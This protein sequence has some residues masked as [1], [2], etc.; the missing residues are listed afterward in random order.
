VN[1]T[2]VI[3]GEDDGAGN[4][5]FIPKYLYIHPQSIMIP[6]GQKGYV[7]IVLR[8]EYKLRYNGIFDVNSIQAME[9]ATVTTAY[10]YNPLKYTFFNGEK[11]GMFLLEITGTQAFNGTDKKNF[12]LIVN[13]TTVFNP[14]VEVIIVPD[15]P[16]TE[17]SQILSPGSLQS[18]YDV[19]AKTRNYIT[20]IV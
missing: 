8:Q 13:G 5:D 4:G 6:A 14:V 18:V 20:F 3:A 12:Y 11:N 9:D 7:S 16:D 1:L 17:K 15:A 2:I 19:E 10:S